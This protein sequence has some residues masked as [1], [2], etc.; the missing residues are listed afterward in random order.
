MAE[1]SRT[2]LLGLLLMASALSAGCS[3]WTSEREA[4]PGLLPLRVGDYATY[5][6]VA[7]TGTLAIRVRGIQDVLEYGGQTR[8]A[9]VIDRWYNDSTGYSTHF[10]EAADPASGRLYWITALCAT[11]DEQ[12]RCDRD[13]ATLSVRGEPG[14]LSRSLLAN[15]ESPSWLP[16]PPGCWL[17]LGEHHPVHGR[18]LPYGLPP[19]IE[20]GGNVSY[21]TGQSLPAAFGTI[22]GPVFVGTSFTRGDGAE[23]AEP[24]WENQ[25]PSLEQ[26]FGQAW[27]KHWPPSPDW[28]QE[29]AY[30]DALQWLSKNSDEFRGFLEAFPDAYLRSTVIT[31]GGGLETGAPLVGDQLDESSVERRIIMQSSTGDALTVDVEKRTKNFRASYSILNALRGHA[32]P[33]LEPANVTATMMSPRDATQDV[34]SR[35]EGIWQETQILTTVPASVG[36]YDGRSHYLYQILMAPPDVEYDEAGFLQYFPYVV[37]LRADTG[38]WLHATVHHGLFG[39]REQ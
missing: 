31:G 30:D 1:S 23:I 9:L 11:R 25:L 3:V 14:Y 2:V 36:T 19:V 5:E 29:F 10:V 24:V 15:P 8:T 32:T 37:L 17:G 18:S 22:A 6:E 7:S 16:Q 12:G 35:V 21:C 20:I 33:T 27:N 38:E 13:V 4:T 28:P 26:S 34:L 39:V